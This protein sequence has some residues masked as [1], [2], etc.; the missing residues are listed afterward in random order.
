MAIKS[1]TFGYCD[2]L[3][4]I[5]LPDGIKEIEAGAFTACN[6]L[7][8][9]VLPKSLKTLGV[10]LL[11]HHKAGRIVSHSP[12]FVVE[13]G[14]LLNRQK[15][16]LIACFNRD[17]MIEVPHSVE[18]IE[19][20]AFA[21]CDTLEWISIG[22][23]VKCIGQDAFYGCINLSRIDFPVGLKEIESCAFA[24]CNSLTDV[25]LPAGVVTLG[26]CAFSNCRSLRHL[27]LSQSLETI[28]YGVGRRLRKAEVPSPP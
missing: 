6:M 17:A 13:H 2:N 7:Q 21:D 5:E 27:V 11:W 19:R 10:P 23:S 25:V 4:Q 24:E 28:P 22:T 1:H 26:L 16:A 14:M 9:I 8:E 18:I 3:R 20:G 15:S 12:E